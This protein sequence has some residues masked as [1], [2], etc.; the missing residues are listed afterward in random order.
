M[1]PGYKAT[2]PPGCYISVLG[3]SIHILT[4]VTQTTSISVSLLP[5]HASYLGLFALAFV[6]WCGESLVKL[7]MCSDVPGCLGGA[8]K[9]G[10]FLL[11]SCEVAFWTQETLPRLPDV[12]CSVAPY[13]VIVIG[14]ALT[15]AC[16]PSVKVRHLL[17]WLALASYPAQPKHGHAWFSLWVNPSP[18]QSTSSLPFP[19][20]DFLS[21]EGKHAHQCCFS[22]AFRVLV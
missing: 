17:S 21:C 12:E 9:S 8:W 6:T 1:S 11:Y 15:S 19:F 18:S 16:P 2:S 13:S 3:R 7:V 22:M 14:S 4:I 10:T 20:Q 5:S